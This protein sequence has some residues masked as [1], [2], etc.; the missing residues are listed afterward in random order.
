MKRIFALIRQDLANSMRDSIILYV[1]VAPFIL[2]L[3]ARLIIPSVATIEPRFAVLESASPRL[4]AALGAYGEVRPQPNRDAFNRRIE[5]TDDVPGYLFEDGELRLVLAGDEQAESV[6]LF[7]LVAREVRAELTS[8]T[9]AAEALTTEWTLL[10]A[11]SSYLRE[12]VLIGLLFTSVLLAGMVQGFTVVEDRGTKAY[13]ALAVSPLRLTEYIAAKVLVVVGI[14]VLTVSGGGLILMGGSVSVL[15]LLMVAAAGSF[16][17]TVI[18]LVMGIFADN[19]IGAIGLAKILVPVMGIVPLLAA[20]FDPGV[21]WT[22]FPFPHYWLFQGMRYWLIGEYSD[23]PGY[24]ASLGIA[25]GGGLVV[26]TVIAP[27]IRRRLGLR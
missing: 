26:L 18:G 27:G 1:L 21:Q 3:V 5:A 9:G 17:S 12:Y 24:W 25:F 6:E 11:Q 8:G 16:I 4:I 19:Q 14:S 23:L 2:A 20:L 22:L 13:Q 7:R 10:E 15:R